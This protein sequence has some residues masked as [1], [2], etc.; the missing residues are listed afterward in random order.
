MSYIEFEEELITA[1]IDNE[2]IEEFE[3]FGDHNISFF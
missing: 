1:P 2:I 3:E